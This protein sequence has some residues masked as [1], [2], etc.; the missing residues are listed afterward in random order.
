M[1]DAQTS[2]ALMPKPKREIENWR[3]CLGFVLEGLTW[4]GVRISAQKWRKHLDHG[5]YDPSH[6]V[7]LNQ[8]L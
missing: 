4:F 7:P 3:E 6:A 5:G 2:L 8:L 1:G